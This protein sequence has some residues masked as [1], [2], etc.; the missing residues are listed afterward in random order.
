MNE[1]SQI[2]LPLPPGVEAIQI[3]APRLVPGDRI[4]RLGVIYEFLEKAEGRKKF[5]RIDTGAEAWID[6]TDLLQQMVSREIKMAI[7][8][9]VPEHRHKAWQREFHTLAEHE[10]R[11]A[12]MR[13]AYVEA[14]LENRKR[15]Y[16][17]KVGTVR[18]AVHLERLRDPAN[19]RAG[20]TCPCLAAIYEWV[21]IIE[22]E[23]G[24]SG[25]RRLCFAE[26]DRGVR[27]AQIAEEMAP[28]IMEAIRALWFTAQRLKVRVIFDRVIAT[29]AKQGIPAGRHPCRQTIRRILKALPPYAAMSARKGARAADDKYR[30]KGQMAAT[31]MPGQVYEV[32]AHKMDFVGVDDRWWLPLGRLWVTVVID[33]CTRMIVGVHFHVEPPS[34]ITIAAALRNAFAPK[35]YMLKRWPGIGRP[36]VAWGLPALVVLDNGLENHAIFLTEGFEELGVDWI[37]APARTPEFKAHIERWFGTFTRDLSQRLPGWTGAN[38]KE[39]GDYDSMGTACLT[40]SQVDELIHRWITVYNIDWHEGLRDIPERLYLE[41]TADLEVTPIEDMG[42]LDVLLGDYVIRT[43]S[44]KGI[45]LLGLRFGDTAGNNA[46]EMIRTRAGAEGL[47]QVRVRYDRS[48]LSHIHVQDP[49]TKEYFWLASLDPAYT[50]GLT[51]AQHRIIRRHAVERCRG[52]VTVAELCTARDDLQRRIE[53]MT[54]HEPMS[55]RKFAT[56]FNGIGSKG[57]WA[58][59]YRLAEAEYAATKRDERGLTVVEMMDDEEAGTS[60]CPADTRTH[61]PTPTPAPPANAFEPAKPGP[62]GPGFAA[63]AESLGMDFDGVVADADEKQPEAADEA[64]VAAVEDDL[65]ARMAALGME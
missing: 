39:K 57:S 58:D 26:R 21:K 5:R 38:P 22:Q 16:P 59:F 33:R 42:M 56:M 24:P 25:I 40:L 36:W 12:K 46:L 27:G 3:A 47:T 6:N 14:F 30:S 62:V 1:M 50:T 43:P 51:L 31:A 34:S 15:G 10:K 35:L 7:P 44:A 45:F 17:V 63:R 48:D 64:P 28:I 52:Y 29:A 61:P 8:S 65:D 2:Q 18:H 20:E 11:R 9:W 60:A 13:F 54:G 53:E 23:S 55:E 19:V 37:F 32:D 41:L 4:D 49:V